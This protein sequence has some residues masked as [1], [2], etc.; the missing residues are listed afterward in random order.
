MRF[1]VIFSYKGAWFERELFPENETAFEY[2]LDPLLTVDPLNDCQHYS[3]VT[4]ADHGCF[5]TIV[6]N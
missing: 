5:I 2:C 3:D 4:S 6:H 1:L